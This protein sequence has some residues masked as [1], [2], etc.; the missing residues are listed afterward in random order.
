MTRKTFIGEQLLVFAA[1]CSVCTCELPAQAVRD[2]AGIRIVMNAKPAWTASQQLRLS[3]EPTL[4][5]GTQDNET[6]TLKSVRGAFYLSDGRIVV[7][8][9]I[10]AELRVYDASGKYRSTFGHKGE[11][12][13]EFRQFGKTVRLAGDTIAVLHDDASI[14]RFTS[15]GRFVSRTGD[16]PPIVGMP[17]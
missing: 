11:A 15:S 17:T 1:I 14:S 8:E 4:V 13:G 3:A 2:S 12:P 10:A 16:Q 7:G 6:Q 9:R 5:V